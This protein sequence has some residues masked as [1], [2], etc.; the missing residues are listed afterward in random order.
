MYSLKNYNVHEYFDNITENHIGIINNKTYLHTSILL[1]IGT[2]YYYINNSFNRAGLLLISTY[3]CLYKFIRSAQSKMKLFYE[4]TY[5]MILI[6]LMIL[7]IN[8]RKYDAGINTLLI[9]III[10]TFISLSIK[11]RNLNLDQSNHNLAKIGKLM[12][13]TTNYIY[14]INNSKII[15][16]HYQKFWKIFDLHFLTFVMLLLVLDS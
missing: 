16:I 12:K 15:D 3:F 11:N 5:F 2:L 1:T 14:P 10:L 9:F 6:N 8:N 4:I 13:K 7:I